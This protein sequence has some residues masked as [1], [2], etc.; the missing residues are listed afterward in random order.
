M[1]VVK[2]D[3]NCCNNVDIKMNKV[4][5]NDKD[6]STK[7]YDICDDCFSK[8]MN[9]I[10]NI[11]IVGNTTISQVVNAD[12]AVVE[13]EVIS[14]ALH[15]DK[16]SKRLTFKKIIDT[17]GIDKLKEEY[18]VKNRSAGDLAM[19]LGISQVALV[20]N[21]NKLGIYKRKPKNKEHM[22]ANDKKEDN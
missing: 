16:G 2:C 22:T 4:T 19:E 3:C 20:T 14:Q 10:N 5:I 7:V 15:N 11:N 6:G 8:I 13:N 1:R 18:L 17:Y 21:L 9:A 12:K